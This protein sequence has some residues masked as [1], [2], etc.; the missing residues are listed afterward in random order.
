VQRTDE[1]PETQHSTVVSKLR[2]GCPVGIGE[3]DWQQAITDA[4]LF[5]ERWAEQAHAF[6][7]TIRELFG[8]APLPERSSPAFRRLSRYDLTGLIWLRAP[9]R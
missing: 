5:M 6:G 7:W 2:R 8:L 9:S 3:A 4:E 1:T